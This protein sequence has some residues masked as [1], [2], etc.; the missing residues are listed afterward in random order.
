M[1]KKSSTIDVPNDNSA[2]NIK[3]FKVLK[4]MQNTSSESGF[5]DY[6]G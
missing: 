3:L 6:H 5:R 4:L 1:K 2:A